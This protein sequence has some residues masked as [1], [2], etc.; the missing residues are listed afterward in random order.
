VLT[1]APS[2][3]RRRDIESA[4]P[5]VSAATIRLVINALRD[6]GLIAVQG[7]GPSARWR[8]I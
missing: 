3:F 5:E 8:R 1:Q 7:A 4:L 6:E 2:E